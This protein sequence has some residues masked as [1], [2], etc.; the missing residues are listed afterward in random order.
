MHLVN[1]HCNKWD[2]DFRHIFAIFC[3]LDCSDYKGC[4]RL[5]NGQGKKLFWVRENWQLEVMSE[6]FEIITLLILH[7]AIEDWNFK[8][9]R[10]LWSVKEMFSLITG[11]DPWLSIRLWAQDFREVIVDEAIQGQINCCLIEIKSK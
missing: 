9:F 8:H 7:L 3:V 11:F 2:K 4:H 1:P 10:S 5:R 6:K